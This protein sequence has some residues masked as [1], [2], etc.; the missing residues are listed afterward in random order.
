MPLAPDGGHHDEPRV[1][2]PPQMARGRR[3]GHAAAPS[4]DAD[5]MRF[6]VEQHVEHRDPRGVGEHGREA[7]NI[8]VLGRPRLRATGHAAA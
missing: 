3:C 5:R 4:E 6:A 1:D 2:E 8:R 7:L